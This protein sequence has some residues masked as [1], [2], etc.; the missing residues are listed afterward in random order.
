MSRSPDTQVLLRIRPSLPDPDE[1][2]AGRGPLMMEAVLSSFHSLKGH[3][4]QVGL[5][6]G[7]ADGKIGLFA[8]TTLR[9]APLVESQLYSQ[10]PDAEIERVSS[11]MF[12][13]RAHEEIFTT[14]LVFTDPELFPIKR[15][16]QFV[17][18]ASRQ[19]IDPIAGITSALVRY[20]KPGMRGH[21]QIILTPTGGSLRRR[22][23]KFL[24][25]L[26]KGI[27]KYWPAYANFFTKVH[28]ARGSTRL[29]LWPL[30]LLMGGWRAWF[31][32]LSKT[33]IS[34]FTG[35]ETEGDRDED[36]KMGMRSHDRE[37]SLTA[38]VDKVN[39]LLFLV[40]IRVSVIAPKGIAD[41]AQAKVEEIASSFRQFS[42][43]HCN[44]LK[45]LSI[46]QSSQIPHDFRATPY[47][48]S[49]EEIATIW[50]VPNILVKTPNID[51]V[52]SK[53]VEPPV[54]L[55]IPTPAR[56]ARHPSPETGEGPE[57]SEGGGEELTVLGEAVFR[58]ERTKFGIRVDDRRRHMYVI[59]KT[60]MG[61][62]TLL[63]NMVFSDIQAGK[64]LAVIDPHG[65]LIENVLKMVPAHRT[66]DVILI[67]PADRE[68]PISFNMLSCP[69]PEQRGLVASGLMS[70]FKKLWPDAFSGRM[71]YILRNAL[72]ALLEAEGNS[73]LGIMRIFSDDQFRKK[74]MENV[75]DHLVKTFWEVEY[76][77]WSDKYRT[78]AIAA[79]QN[80]I[81]QLLSTPVIRNIVGQVNSKLDVR[82]AMD[83]GKII[84]ANLSKGKLGED[85]SAFLGAMLVTKF[86]LD[87]MSRADIPENERRDFF[88][89][90]DEFQNFATESFATILS[91]A[92]KYR[93]SLTMAH[94]YIGQL[95]LA[96]NSTALQDAVFGNVGTICSFQVGSDDAEPLSLQFEE[97]VAPKD[98]LSLPKYQAYMRL[99]IKGIPSKPF[100]V[101]TLPP[102]DAQ[103]DA[104]RVETIRRLSR[105]R[106]TERRDAV[107]EKI[108]KWLATAKDA[109]VHAKSVEKQ[110][111]K[112]E[113]EKKKA[114]AK[115]MKL[116]E[117]R[118]WRDR[119]MWINEYNQLRKKRYLAETAGGEPLNDAD[120][121]RWPELEQKLTETGGIPP[122]SKAL[123]G[124]GKK[125]KAEGKGE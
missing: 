121:A 34:L 25:L 99:M 83:S 88:L 58:G 3:N 10:Y 72:L 80:K 70:I 91:E 110:K 15:H 48:M 33:N 103:A 42:L 109:I 85:N 54:D 92:R 40:N 61:K 122:P 20:F 113:E 79:I 112:E 118:K 77:S 18:M 104:K 7:Y 86:Q 89:Y 16:P 24:P 47:V 63:E 105:E 60:G 4:A 30:D 101:S 53:K 65:D 81:G 111:E 76:T 22:S 84:L 52:L 75:S 26:T 29:L 43:P 6:I 125:P 82:H 100:S 93:L 44:G 119:E 11:S 78:E 13:A 56:D 38:A 32:Q 71:E 98:I 64:G 39:R 45:P 19:S 23:L 37:D 27:P 1:V 96:N 46:H 68:F 5:E 8:R 67:E 107:E 50:H 12:A 124:E 117:Y 115:G 66:N 73:M 90:V 9:A 28:F 97:V 51:W 94:Q 74:V 49:V 17:D 106:Y 120:W 87:A 14:D 102:P 108:A 2:S 62:S 55:P 114:R 36:L 95:L 21:V 116:D 59:G 57:P 123:T 35:E 69:N 41:E 31:G